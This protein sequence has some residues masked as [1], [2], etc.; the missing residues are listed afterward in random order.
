M[1]GHRQMGMEDYTG[2]LRRRKWLLIVPAV[3]LSAAAYLVST[4]IP[5]R[6]VSTTSVLI[7]EQ[8]VSDSIVKPIVNGDSS[9]K[10]TT[11]KERILSRTRLQPIV[12]R[13]SLFS[14]TGLPLEDRITK[15]HDAIKVT[16]TAAMEGTRA[17]QLPGFSIEVTLSDPRLAQQVC[18][19]ILSM[20]LDEDVQSG[21][22]E[23]NT[24]MDFL[25][26]EV[27]E[28][29][30][31][32]N[33]QDAKLA[34]FKRHNLGSLPDQE[35]A[36]LN[37]LTS[38]NTQMEAVTQSLDREEQ[39]KSLWESELSQQLAIWRAT[40]QTGGTSPVAIDTALKQKQD[41][42]AKLQEKFTDDWPDVKAKKQEIQE[43]KKQ[44]AD[45]DA[46]N[47]LN[48]PVREKE[49]S[50]SAANVIEPENIQKLRAEIKVSDL[51]IQEKKRQQQ[52]LQEDYKVYQGRVQISP[53][54]EQEYSEL[55]RDNISAKADYDG[56]IH[57][58]DD[59]G[60]SVALQRRQE[61]GGFKPLDPAS[62]PDKPAFPNR[63]LFA[64][65]GFGGGLALGLALVLL[66]EMRDKSFRTE[67]DIE[68]LLKLPTLAMVPVLDASSSLASRI[69][70]RARGTDKAL[71]AKT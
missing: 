17:N 52:K 60:M 51:A 59:S 33:A 19:E 23:N 55:T 64:A 15:L 34:D 26:K 54:V 69:V 7:E 25:N 38:T 32:M 39:N 29:Q 53:M 57:K 58:R 67:S 6:Y 11:M 8:R 40:R 49:D 31:K 10:L 21:A 4:K 44:M 27:E 61:G 18:S 68:A 30:Q 3:L 1:L 16:P 37:L 14:D 35:T 48:P 71:P 36:N 47:K 42:L 43:L 13:F 5:N 2:I 46:A 28:A 20:F 45:A 41:E 56:L 62:L 22:T 9:Q 12:E 50:A 65:S 63:M 24:I 66:L 70:F